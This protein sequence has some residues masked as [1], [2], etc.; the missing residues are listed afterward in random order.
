MSTLL[1]AVIVVLVLV[2]IVVMPLAAVVTA[3]V[4]AVLVGGVA[5]RSRSL[6]LN[7]RQDLL[8]SALERAS[9]HVWVLECPRESNTGVCTFTANIGGKKISMHAGGDSHP[10]LSDTALYLPESELARAAPQPFGPRPVTDCPESVWNYVCSRLS[11]AGALLPGTKF[12]Y[13]PS[14]Q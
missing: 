1:L 14:T 7:E 10:C 12:R 5:L 2:L 13:V 4:A 9:G 6:T 11:D 3:A 8:E